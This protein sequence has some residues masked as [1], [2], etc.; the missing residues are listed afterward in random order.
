VDCHIVESNNI[1][2]STGLSW[3]SIEQSRCTLPSASGDLLQVRDVD[4]IW[5]RRP[6]HPQTVSDKISDPVHVQVINNDCTAALTGLLLN[7]FAGIWINDPVMTIAAQNKLLQLRAAQKCG[8]RVPRTL[9]SQ[10]PAEIRAFIST[11][12]ERIVIK[13][14]R[15][16]IQV[17][18]LTTMLRG[19]DIG[20]EVDESLRVCPALYQEFIPG[21]QHIRV[22]C[23]GESVYAAL[24]ESDD[25][26]W[27]ANYDVPMKQF[28]L[29]SSLRDRLR[30]VLKMLNLRMGI[31]DLKIANDGEPVWFEVNPQGQFLF[32]EGI[33]GMKLSY[34]FAEFLAS[35]AKSR[36]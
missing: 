29:S 24:I 30:A 25:L 13:A 23:F 6:H 36:L 4:V 17:P 2:G 32:V 11:L 26:D 21:R 19:K 27:R 10:D 22:H 15:G 5:W 35:E 1:S 7:E 33:S 20:E 8:F 34:Y 16:T 3:S 28:E 18:I 31:C 14:V 12:G 9:V